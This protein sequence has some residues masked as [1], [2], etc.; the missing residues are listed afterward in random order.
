MANTACR[1]WWRIRGDFNARH[2][3]T[4]DGR[5]FNGKL[6]DLDSADDDPIL[7]WERIRQNVA[8]C[9]DQLYGKNGTERAIVLFFV[10]EGLWLN[11]KVTA[12]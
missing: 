9:A 3:L 5:H 12:G 7:S 1:L 6:P 2:D 8:K 10:C 11:V 4:T